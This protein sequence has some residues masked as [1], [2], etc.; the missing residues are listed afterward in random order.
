MTALVARLAVGLLARTW[1]VHTVGQEHLAR[2]RAG[3]SP[4]IFALWHGQL[5]PLLWH[6]RGHPTT[7][8]AS[9]H[10]D[11]R[12]LAAAATA[13]GFP[14]IPGSSTRGGA[15][16]LRRMI[17]VLRDG[18]EVAVAPDGPRGPRHQVKPG[19]I[20]AAAVTGAPI[21]P[22]TARVSDAW[23][24]RSWDGFVIPK[25][26]ARVAVVYHPPLRV[27]ASAGPTGRATAA[28]RL[29]SRLNT[30]TAAAC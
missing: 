5:L 29:A 6:H 11:G 26:F 4:F 13:W 15:G 16:A 23:R 27:T 18:G 19:A 10:A 21:L 12:L 1:R 17:R 20:A 7:I 2:L 30:P 22:V 3:K 25:P 9:R 14:I 8:V 24:L 28:A